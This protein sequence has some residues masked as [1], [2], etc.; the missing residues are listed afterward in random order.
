MALDQGVLDGVTNANFKLLA[1]SVSTAL[2][3][4]LAIQAQNAASHQQRLQIIAEAS[5]S[6]QLNRANSLDPEEASA[7]NKV[8]QSDLPKMM[9]ELGAQIAA[10]QQLMK[11]A[12]TTLP[13]TG[14][15]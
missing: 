4:A 10:I 5:L 6:Q 15:T 3:Q 11:G 2:G 1:E 12:Q 13:E 7:I 9:S 8:E 14:K